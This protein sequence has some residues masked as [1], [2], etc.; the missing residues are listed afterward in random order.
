MSYIDNRTTI[1]VLTKGAR[2]SARGKQFY[3]VNGETRKSVPLARVLDFVVHNSIQVDPS[4]LLLASKES[5]PIHYINGRGDYY[6][7]FFNGVSRNIF[8]RK[9]QYEKRGEDK[10]L[11]N[12]AR[13]IVVG[14]R[15]NQMWNIKRFRKEGVLPEIKESTTLASYLGQEGKTSKVYWREF[16]S[17]IKN[18]NFQFKR[19]T[20]RPPLD[21][22][23]ALLSFGYT[24][25]SSRITSILLYVG[26]DPYLGFYHQD[27]YKRPAL[28]LDM[29]E[30][31][32]PI[33]VDWFVLNTINRREFS[34]DDFVRNGAFIQL[35]PKA[36]NEF[37]R[38]WF[39]WWQGKEFRSGGEKATLAKFSE[40][41]CRELSKVITGELE[42]YKPFHF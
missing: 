12:F 17:C 25:L 4:A 36:R 10:F 20:K 11:L 33:A 14:K 35:K 39:G 3:I 6:G 13:G 9:R 31:W 30:E 40:W 41:Q 28:A 37:I 2:L 18:P 16:S 42:E 27:F 8:L 19:R 22:M 38:K 26:L 21:E 1:F 15:D 23:N 32:R 34:K 24:L 5:I 29:M 7:S